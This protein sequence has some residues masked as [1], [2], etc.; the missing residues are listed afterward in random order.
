MD[1]VLLSKENIDFVN[2]HLYLSLPEVKNL[3]DKTVE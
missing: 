2:N 1:S 3:E